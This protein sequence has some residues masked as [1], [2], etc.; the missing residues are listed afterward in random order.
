M[1]Y[2]DHI[3][4]KLSALA[5]AGGT[6]AMLFAATPVHT[7]FSATTNGTLS[8]SGAR[9][10]QTLT[11]GDLSATGLLPPTSSTYVTTTTAATDTPSLTMAQ[12]GWNWTNPE[13]VTL[14]NTGSVPETF[15]LN[16][17]KVS[18]GFTG[19]DQVALEQLWV[20]YTAQG[21]TYYYQM[22]PAGDL[23]GANGGGSLATAITYNLGTLAAQSKGSATVAFALAPYAHGEGGANAWNGSGG[24]TI[25]YT[26][27]AEPSSTQPA[28]GTA[29]AP[30]L[31]ATGTSTS[32]P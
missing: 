24:V 28:S 13:T 29:P 1:R 19:N 31:A 9:V 26:I 17:S 23:P 22:F 20:A 15:T 3:V 2:R 4:A 5:V 21:T 12:T 14:D 32:A 25:P 11:N 6:T 18:D 10:A 30:T 7:Q 8:A 16:I 27:T